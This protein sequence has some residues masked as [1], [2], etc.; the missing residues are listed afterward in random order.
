MNDLRKKWDSEGYATPTDRTML[1]DLVGYKAE[2]LES[3][4]STLLG[5]GCGKWDAIWKLVS[6]KHFPELRE[7]I[8]SATCLTASAWHKRVMVPVR[9]LPLEFFLIVRYPIKQAENVRRR[10]AATVIDACLECLKSPYQD[11]VPPPRPPLPLPPPLLSP[12]PPS[13]APLPLPPPP[14]L[15]PPTCWAARGPSVKKRC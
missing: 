10:V 4:F 13:A 5:D 1:C 15:R 3:E 2:A 8:V 9:S 12:P 6:D 14:L 7:F 11:M